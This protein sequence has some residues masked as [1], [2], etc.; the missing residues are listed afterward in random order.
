MTYDFPIPAARGFRAQDGEHKCSVPAP[1]EG[2]QANGLILYALLARVTANNGTVHEFETIYDQENQLLELDIPECYLDFLQNITVGPRISAYLQWL[3]GI[4][5]GGIANNLAW[6]STDE[7]IEL[8]AGKKY[9]TPEPF[10]EDTIAVFING[11]R[12]ER[13]AEDGFAV[14]DDLTFE[15]K[16][17][18]PSG[19][20][21]SAGYMKKASP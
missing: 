8:I 2:L 11:L 1:V 21:I 14:L 4:G 3:V 7:L 12:V 9:R 18:Y 20:R 5:I 6:A 16:E 13:D 15:M 17:T 19:F 10:Y